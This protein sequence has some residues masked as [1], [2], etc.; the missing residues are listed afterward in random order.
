[1][2]YPKCFFFR[3]FVEVAHPLSKLVI[4]KSVI[5][6]YEGICTKHVAAG[7]HL[8]PTVERVKL[9]VSAIHC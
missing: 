6:V 9:D 3:Q 5:Q 2:A 4:V 8:K 7:K 1:M